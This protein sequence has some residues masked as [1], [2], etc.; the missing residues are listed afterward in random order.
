MNYQSIKHQKVNV[1]EER[2][3]CAI[4][5]FVDKQGNSTHDNIVRTIDALRQMGHRSGDING[6]GDGCGIMTDIPREIWARRLA[7]LDLSPHLAESKHF[8]VGHLLLP[9]LSQSESQ[10]I[11]IRTK[12]LFHG[13]KIDFLVER[14]GKTNDSEL[15]PRARAE[16]PLFWQMCGLTP[17][18]SRHASQKLLFQLQLEI[19]KKI[20]EIHT[21]SLSLDTVIYKLQGLPDLLPRV[22]PE[23]RDQEMRSAM[24]LGHGRYS[25]N[26]LPTVN[27]SQPFSLLGHNGEINTIERLRNIGRTLGIDPVPGGSDSQD[28]NRV[29]EGLIHFHNLELIEAMEMVFPAIHSETK[30]YSQ[31]IREICSFY[32]WFFPCSAQ[33]PAAVL[34]RLGDTCLGSVDAMGLRPLWFGESDYTYFLSSEKGVVSLANTIN[35]PCPLA[36]GEKITITGGRGRRAEVVAYGALQQRMVQLHQSRGPSLKHMA[37]LYNALPAK[38]STNEETPQVAIVNGLAG[39][40]PSDSANLGLASPQKLA[41]FGWRHYDFTIRQKV[42][43]SGGEVIGSMGYTG[44]LA[45]FVPESLPN[46]ADYCKENVAVVTNPAIDREREAEH[47]STM[48]VLGRRPDIARERTNTPLGLELRIPILLGHSAL[49]GLLSA[50]QCQQIG[51]FHGAPLFENILDFFTCQGRDSTLV[52]VLDATFIPA[53]GLM[54]RLRVLADEA[55]EAVTAGALLLVVDDSRS[56]SDGRVFI[57]PIVMVAHL[58]ES[59]IDSGLRREASLIV[60][61]GAIRNLHDLMLVIGVGADAVHPYLLWQVSAGYANDKQNSAEVIEN[62]FS[63]LQKGMEKV[64]STMGIHELC[65]YGRIFSAIGLRSD[66]AK[67]L[68]IS[69]FCG[70]ESFGLGIDELEEMANQRYLRAN[71]DT[72][73]EVYREP[74]RNP[75]VGRIIR[76]V[77][78]GKKGYLEMAT[79]LD[80]IAQELPTGIRHLLKTKIAPPAEQLTMN[81]VDLSVGEHSLPLLIAAMSFGSQGENSFR[82]YA[83]AAQKANIICMNG[84]GGEI[85]DMLGRYRKNR[86]QQIASGRFGVFMGF[87]NSADFLE[88][89]IGQGA[90]PGEGGHLPGSKVSSMV[91]MARHCKTG[92]TLISPSN[93]HDIYSIEDLAQIITELKTANPKAKVSVKI[94]VT[95]GVGTISV[96]VAKAGADIVNISGYEG[97]TGAAREHA[98]RF[99]GL[100]VEIG[101]SEA[102]HALVES[103]LRQSIEIWADG[104]IRSGDDILKLILLGANRVGLGTLA[105]MGIGCISCRKCHLDSCPRG[106]STQVKT[107]EESLARGNKGFVPRDIEE[108]S[109]NLARLLNALGDELRMRT[110]EMGIKRLQDLVGRGDLLYQH[111]LR[112]QLDTDDLLREATPPCV[113][114]P[115]LTSRIIRKPLSYF[116][117]LISDLAMAH[118]AQGET[119][120]HFA[121]DGVRST[122]RAVG[123]YLAGALSRHYDEAEGNKRL[124]QIRLGASVPGN[125]LSA[126][127]TP[128]V[129]V[130]VEGG[131]QDGAAKGSMGGLLVVLKSQNLLG[132]YIDG[133]TGK[134]FAYGATG[135]LFMVQN[136][137]DSR[138]CVRMSGADAIFGGMITV[139]VQDDLGN[140]ASR[141]HLKGFAFEY[142]TGGRAVVL[143]DPGPW[144]CAG[145]TGGVI[146][147]CIYPEF[148]FTRES[149][150]KRLSVSAKVTISPIDQDG[151]RDIHELLSRYIAELERGFQSQEAQVVNNIMLDAGNR[152]VMIKPKSSQ[153]LLAE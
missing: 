64:M 6:E 109:E 80:A 91:A 90:K 53:D 68:R 123:T 103:G 129:E 74:E 77:A 116:T 84:E 9:P 150:A 1:I 86:G 102:H 62:T 36:P 57:D 85:P 105:L 43:Q 61:S 107:K 58:Q 11:M 73:A 140:I 67:I 139:P 15:G 55:K 24:T 12:E 66:L 50:N 141:A 37:S 111:R 48:T 78:I 27:R 118:F 51:Q 41:A 121:E 83:E 60:S 38:T 69:N 106:I 149:V 147:Q 63:V 17:N 125:G 28:L 130:I 137:A 96:G 87:L 30:H 120:V 114:M 52:R 144:I 108:E 29:I 88:I 4:V 104:G 56:F 98:K 16:A 71:S 23:L 100:P 112:E 18:S 126:F 45:S 19:E 143:G 153:P 13:Y 75:K 5:A 25:T 79:A 59:L 110:A 135:G 46:V 136:M 32:R 133:S 47:F 119:H 72:K 92:I 44:P 101:V 42:A 70:S 148:N 34:A 127:N 76:D 131:S 99:V 39:N 138:A 33:G 35:D 89:K 2:D 8:F 132:R 49:S 65:G 151:L 40:N 117:R 113:P 122:D 95:S 128:S 31:P 22:Y 115:M 93:H 20:P 134:S 97:G 94:P 81:E 124:A 145:M 146:Y 21:A 82:A 54:K 152:F 3:A 7:E 14:V 10:D 26:T 142:M